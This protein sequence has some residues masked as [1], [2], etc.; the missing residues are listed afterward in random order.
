[1]E[2]LIE[3]MSL[4]SSA[5]VT[6]TSKNTAMKPLADP[7]EACAEFQDRAVTDLDTT[8]AEFDEI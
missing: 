3:G 2:C 7:G 4:R 8:R 6:G 1:M 5:R